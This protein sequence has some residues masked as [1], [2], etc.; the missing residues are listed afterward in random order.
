M[1]GSILEETT[2]KTTIKDL[3][4]VLVEPTAQEDTEPEVEVDF[5]QDLEPV[6][7]SDTCLALV[8]IEDITGID[9][10]VDTIKDTMDTEEV[11]AEEPQE[12]L[13]LD[14]EAAAE[15]VDLLGLVQPLAMVVPGVAEFC[16]N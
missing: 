7:Y 15:V 3:M 5:G 8:E 1:V 9:G 16:Q 2:D 4:T 13:P 14:L 11:G 6:V 10:A 12:D